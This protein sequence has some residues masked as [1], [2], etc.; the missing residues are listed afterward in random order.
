MH[1]GL[2]A[3]NDF[4]AR[5]YSELP[6]V[7]PFADDYA[8]G[9][10]HPVQHWVSKDLTP[11]DEDQAISGTL[12]LDPEVGLVLYVLIFGPDTDLRAQVARALAVRSRLLPEALQ[13]GQEKDPHGQW[14]VAINW[15][16]DVDD[17]GAW[18]EQAARLRS[19]TGHLEEIPIDAV[20]RH[21]SGW[22][23]AIRSHGLPRLLL[24]TRAVLRR[25]AGEMERWAS[26]DVRVRDALAGFDQGFTHPEQRA[27]ALELTNWLA[28]QSG[29]VEPVAQG[30][31]ADAP[32]TITHLGVRNL[33]NLK[34]IDLHFGIDMPCAHI[35]QGPNGTG[36]SNLL[37]ALYLALSG[38]SPRLARFSAD[39]DLTARR[40]TAAVYL[41]SYLRP[42]GKAVQERPLILL[43]GES[44]PILDDRGG[45]PPAAPRLD[46]N[47]LSQEG[48]RGFLDKD[49]ATLAAEALGDYSSLADKARA[50]AQGW[51]ADAKEAQ[52]SLLRD[53][54]LNV[55][56]TKPETACTRAARR[57]LDEVA[58]HPASLVRWLESPALADL[59]VTRIAAELADAWRSLGER[60]DRLAS[61]SAELRDLPELT[62]R[63]MTYLDERERLLGRCRGLVPVVAELAVHREPDLAKWARDWGQWLSVPQPQGIPAD[64]SEAARL[65]REQGELQTALKEL[66][67][68]GQ[69]LAAREQHLAAVERFLDAHWERDHPDDCPTCGTHLADRGG[70]RLAMGQQ[71]EENARTLEELRERYR[72]KNTRL[73]EIRKRIGAPKGGARPLTPDQETRVIAALG[74]LLP[75]G[76]GVEDALRNAA[77]LDRLLRLVDALRHLPQIPEAL[78][79]AQVAAQAQIL[80]RDMLDAFRR[81]DDTFAA[82]SAW[83]AVVKRLDQRLAQIVDQHLPDTLGAL[84]RELLMNLTPAT[85]QL[86]GTPALRVDTRDRKTTLRVQVGDDER[87]PLARYMLNS[88][89]THCVGLAWFLVRY[90]TQGRFR[91]ALLGLDDPAQEMDQTTYRDLCRLWGALLRLHGVH[92]LPLTLLVLLHQD[93]RALDAAR[94]TDGTLHVL[95]WNRDTPALARSLRLAGDQ[96][97]AP[98]PTAILAQP[99][100]LA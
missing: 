74:Q 12:I 75:S 47:L 93:E 15:L 76:E 36:K 48:S 11:G 26:A 38:T 88:A 66:T 64:N 100:R 69:A 68:N 18:I 77:R 23:T 37:E 73:A 67:R 83:Q 78:A 71:R 39:K 34:A 4:L 49:A 55:N 54:G 61:E 14:R 86:P 2:E 19:E 27:A 30:E 94:A 29:V 51:L 89:E 46:G 16:V 99:V 33:R 96:G 24:T 1:P 79:P 63:V 50:L 59:S 53:Y 85:W 80:A 90:L 91:I 82:P 81:V 10:L 43:N 72:E 17:E 25:G 42:R 98:A 31:S 92:G 84:W 97:G 7:Y 45:D 57:R 41:D 3:V 40:R 28:Q 22:P 62:E 35:V 6:G 60:G 52:H 56:I 5:R 21:G 44:H 95:K 32:L 13:R 9:S 70:I 58:P 87:G 65:A 20:L 8:L